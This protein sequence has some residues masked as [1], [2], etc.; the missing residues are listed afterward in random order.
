MS[1][2]KGKAMEKQVGAFEA[3]RQLGRVLKEVAGKGDRYIVEY[4]GEPVAAIVPMP[5][6][7]QWKVE[8][9]EFFDDMRAIAERANLSEEEGEQL[10]AE[11]IAAVRASKRQ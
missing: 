11:A 2:L 6:Y 10:V 9:K 1:S 5:L 3:R 4:H 8:R 7:E